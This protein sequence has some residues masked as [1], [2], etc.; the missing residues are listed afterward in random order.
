MEDN[1]Y[2]VRDRI[3]AYHHAK[4]DTAAGDQARYDE[5]ERNTRRS[6]GIACFAVVEKGGE[7]Q[8]KVLLG[9]KRF[10]YALNEIAQGKY[11]ADRAELAKKFDNMYLEDKL[12][13]ASMTFDYIW[14]RVWLNFN[15]TS[16]YYTSKSKFESTF[17]VDNGNMLRRLIEH[18]KNKPRVW[19]VPK[20]RKKNRSEA[21][22]NC[23]MREFQE[24]TGMTSRMYK[25]YTDMKR[26]YTFT[27]NGITYVNT[28]YLAFTRTPIS[29]EIS[30]KNKE[31]VDEIGELK[32][33]NIDEIRAVD[34]SGHLENVIKPMLNY[35]RN[36][37]RE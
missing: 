29:P 6:V 22:I 2:N 21:D 18:S 31:Q 27:D 1:K 25:L 3:K 36:R 15:R 10:S 24:E 35:V 12:V 32:W 8:L 17:L 14:Y 37:L 30:L 34:Q 26:T 28:Y 7:K 33:M 4:P 13:V 20:G 11:T 23:A 16:A 5:E 9:T 19:E